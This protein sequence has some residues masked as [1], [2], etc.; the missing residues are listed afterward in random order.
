[1]TVF[2]NEELADALDDGADRIERE[3]WFNSDLHRL[4]ICADICMGH[5]RRADE[6]TRALTLYIGLTIA[7]CFGHYE[8]QQWN[9]SFDSPQPVLDAM[10]GCAKALRQ[11]DDAL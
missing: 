2:T 6:A 8:L 10:R 3:G 5:G 9:D 4:G 1:M 7:G 11:M